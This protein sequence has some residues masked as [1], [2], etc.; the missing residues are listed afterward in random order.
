[1][2]Y[3]FIMKE[4]SFSLPK[5]ILPKLA[6]KIDDFYLAGGTA[7][8]MFHYQHR[9]S[10]DLDFFTKEFSKGRIL[11]IIDSLKKDSGW[12]IELISE[13]NKENMIRI[14]VYMVN[15]PNKQKCKIDFVEDCIELLNSPKKVD[16][17][18]ILSLEDI[19]LRKI[20]TIAGHI[21]TLDNIGRNVLLGSRQE[22]KDFYDIY[23]LSSIT[24]PL[25]EFARRYCNNTVKEGIVRWYR[26]YD[27]MDMKHG[28]LELAAKTKPD[29]RLIE[30][31]FKKE[32]DK[33]LGGLIEGE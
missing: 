16:G 27:R 31:H 30:N 19:Y 15:L 3:T 11:K 5:Q 28:L 24:L 13:Q 22:A 1:M 25:S 14:A 10:F 18:N 17:I 4:I 23:C 2:L 29:Y 32:V 26:T 33:L 6:D 8:S 9:E 7:L 20:Y 21:P 12:D